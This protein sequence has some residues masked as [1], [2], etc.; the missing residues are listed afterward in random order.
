MSFKPALSNQVRAGLSGAVGILALDAVLLFLALSR[1]L[2]GLSFAMTL[3]VL[4]SLPLLAHVLY[5]TYGVFTLEYWVDRD[6]VTVIWGVT[7]QIIPILEVQKVVR[8]QVGRATGRRVWPVPW[9]R[10]WHCPQWGE[11]LSYATAPEQLLLVTASATYGISPAQPEAFISALQER[12]RLGP[13]HRRRPLVWHPAWWSHPLWSDRLGLGLL[14][15]GVVLNLA[16]FGI[17][18]WRFSAL[19]ADLPLHFDALGQPDRIGSR[20]ALFTVPVLGLLSW[21]LNG[22]VGLWQYR[23]QRLAA[24]LLWTGAMAVQVLAWVALRDLGV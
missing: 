24:Y 3:S 17:L 15:A 2:G 12:H 23:R 7:Q 19:P 8:D 14:L 18:S 16:L 6:S 13:M 1:P 4:L 20:G 21:I 9:V 5:R 11:V 10:R 22:F